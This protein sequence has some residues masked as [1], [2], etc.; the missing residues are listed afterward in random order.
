M[1]NKQLII[2]PSIIEDESLEGFIV[3]LSYLNGYHDF[4]SPNKFQYQF[5]TYISDGFLDSAVYVLNVNF[6]IQALEIMMKNHQE[7]WASFYFKPWTFFQPHK[8]QF[9]V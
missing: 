9:I 6:I 2:N 4:D 1:K 5:K 7:Q 8:C 3:R